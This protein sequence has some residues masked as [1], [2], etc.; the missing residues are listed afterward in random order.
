M[1]LRFQTLLGSDHKLAIVL[2]HDTLTVS[3]VKTF[4]QS[5]GLILELVITQPVQREVVSYGPSSASC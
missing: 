2:L 1:F 5:G 3:S 4:H